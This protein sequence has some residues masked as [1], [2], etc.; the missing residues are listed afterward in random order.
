M[1]IVAVMAGLGLRKSCKII[2][3]SIYRLDVLEDK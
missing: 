3:C 2:D 1:W